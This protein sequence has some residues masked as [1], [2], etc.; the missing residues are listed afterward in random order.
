MPASFREIHKRNR[1]TFGAR[2]A[3]GQEEMAERHGMLGVY[4]D[5]MFMYII[6]VR[7]MARERGISDTAT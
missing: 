1:S 7:S 4:K 3:G 6:W 2:L 5:R